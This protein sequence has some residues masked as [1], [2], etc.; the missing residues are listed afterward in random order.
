MCPHNLQILS[1][2]PKEPVL[3]SAMK[4]TSKSSAGASLSTEELKQKKVRVVGI[5][6]KKKISR[7]MGSKKSAAKMGM[8]GRKK[9]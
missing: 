8:L 1:A 6:K 5:E 4:K 2:S 9:V 7:E 3:K